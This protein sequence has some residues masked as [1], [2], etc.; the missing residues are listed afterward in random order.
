MIQEMAELID[1]GHHYTQQY[2]LRNNVF[3][4]IRYTFRPQKAIVSHCK[5]I[6]TKFYTLDV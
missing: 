3:L 2:S 1:K 6:K 4:P 5:K